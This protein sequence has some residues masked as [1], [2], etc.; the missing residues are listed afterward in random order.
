MA[1]EDAVKAAGEAFLP[2]LELQTDAEYG[3]Y[4]ARASFFNATSRTAD[5]FLGLIFRRAPFVR[6]PDVKTGVGLA[7]QRF[8][9]D[10]DLSGTTLAIYLNLDHYRLD[11]DYKHG[12]HFTALPTAW[13]AGFEKKEELTIGS[14]T[15]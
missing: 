8:E 15:A 4:K 1:G 13:V 9:N 12:V 3:A 14:R 6:L 11:A 10:V 5:G 7:L 2:R